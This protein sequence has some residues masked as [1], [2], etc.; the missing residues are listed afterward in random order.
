MTYSLSWTP[1]GD[2]RSPSWLREQSRCWSPP[3]Y[4]TTC[5][6]SC[7]AF[8]SMWNQARSARRNI[9][10]NDQPVDVDNTVDTVDKSGS[11]GDAAQSR[12]SVSGNRPFAGNESP[13][14]VL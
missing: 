10:T 3:R 12:P 13:E 2:P 1:G 8:D 5:R 14:S 4:R 11:A 6:A 7:E 9:S